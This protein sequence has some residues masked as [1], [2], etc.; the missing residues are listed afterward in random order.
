VRVG[1]TSFRFFA[2][3]IL[4]RER[5]PPVFRTATPA[6]NR[7]KRRHS[8]ALSEFRPLFLN[9]MQ[10]SVNRKVQGSNPWSG[11]KTELEIGLVHT[12]I[13]LADGAILRNDMYDRPTVRRWSQGR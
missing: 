3:Q 6:I 1:L 4:N 10:R 12:Q 5:P 7:G 11:A 8:A 13:A 2:S 9:G